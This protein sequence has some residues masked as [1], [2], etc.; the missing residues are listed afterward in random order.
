MDFDNLPADLVHMVVI[1]VNQE[2]IHISDYQPEAVTP[3]TPAEEQPVT[4][5]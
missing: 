2:P 4:V 1:V 3:V 5:E